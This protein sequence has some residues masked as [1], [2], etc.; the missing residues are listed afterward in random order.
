MELTIMVLAALFVIFA[1]ATINQLLEAESTSNFF[2]VEKKAK[3]KSALYGA[4]FTMVLGV[5]TIFSISF[6]G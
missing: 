5:M 6:L 3:F 2:M 1:L 4:I